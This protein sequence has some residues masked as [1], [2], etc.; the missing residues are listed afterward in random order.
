MMNRLG[1]HWGL[2]VPLC[3]SLS[4][5]R[6]WFFPGLI[7][8]DDFIPYSRDVLASYFPW[9]YFWDPGFHLGAATAQFSPGF[10]I[11][12]ASGA[13]A[14]L[15]F[16]WS[17]SE[18]LFWLFPY[19][20]G[21]PLTAYFLC[22]RLTRNTAAA[23]CGA[24]VFVLN[25]W[26][27]G[28]VQR[29][30]IPSLV[31]YTCMPLAVFGILKLN[32]SKTAKYAVALAIVLSV[33]VMYDLRYTYITCWLLIA[34]ALAYIIQGQSAHR[35]V[36]AVLF[37]AIAMAT[38]LAINLRWL[39]P[40][41]VAPTPFPPG[42]DTVDALM[43][44]SSQLTLGHALTLFY[45]FYH[46]VA[47]SAP[48]VRSQAEPL[49][50]IVPA[51]I[52]IG[53]AFL[54]PRPF[55]VGVALSALV[56]I[57]LVSGPASVV[58]LVSRWAF[59]HV[60]GMKLFRDITKWYS[61][62]AVCYAVLVSLTIARLGA[63]WQRVSTL[64]VLIPAALSVVFISIYVLA[65]HDAWN[66]QRL[67]NFA[68]SAERPEDSQL[69]QYINRLPGNS[70]VLVFP[71][72]TGQ[73]S[74]TNRHGIVDGGLLSTW[75]APDG[76]ASETT[77]VT[78][79][80]SFY[81]T[82]LAPI[83]MRDLNIAYFAVLDDPHGAMYRPWGFG[84]E[85]SDALRTFRGLHWLK[86]D[87]HFG[88]IVL[89]HIT[90]PGLAAYTASEPIFVDGNRSAQTAATTGLIR[91]FDAWMPA[92]NT[93]EENGHKYGNSGD[94]GGAFT[95]IRS[96]KSF[97]FGRLTGT[98]PFAERARPVFL[99]G[100][101]R[102]D[103][104]KAFRII[105]AFDQRDDAIVYEPEVFEKLGG[106]VYPLNSVAPVA[107]PPD[108]LNDGGALESAPAI[109]D[110]HQ[111]YKFG[112]HG[113]SISLINA[114]SS[115][116]TTRITFKGIYSAGNASCH[117]RIGN[118]APLPISNSVEAERQR[119]TV[120]YVA[121][122]VLRPGIN[123]MPVSLQGCDSR[124]ILF[125]DDVTLANSPGTTTS[126][127]ATSGALA[128]A[129]RPSR[130]VALSNRPVFSIYADRFPSDPPLLYTEFRLRDEANRARNFAFPLSFRYRGAYE[131]DIHDM[132]D[133]LVHD[134][135]RVPNVHWDEIGAWR[136]ESIR[137][138]IDGPK[139]AVR[140]AER[141]LISALWTRDGDSMHYSGSV[142]LN[143]A[144]ATSSTVLER[145]FKHE[146]IRIPAGTA[147]ADFTFEVPAPANAVQLDVEARND[148]AMSASVSGRGWKAGLAGR[149]SPG[150]GAKP[151]CENVK[152]VVPT[153]SLHQVS[154][155]FTIA[156]PPMAGSN[157][158]SVTLRLLQNQRDSRISRIAGIGNIVGLTA[159]PL[160]TRRSRPFANVLIDGVSAGRKIVTLRPGAHSIDGRI[161]DGQNVE[162]S[163]LDSGSEHPH[164]DGDRLQ[165]ITPT[166]Y[167]AAI[168]GRGIFVWPNGYA[169]GWKS[170]AISTETHLHGIAVLDYWAART[171]HAQ[172]L[173]H[174]VVDESINGWSV[175]SSKAGP[176]K[177]LL[178]LY[179][180][181]V[182]SELA[183]FAS[184]IIVAFWLLFLGIHK[185]RR[186]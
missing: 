96:E 6:A 20:I 97:L 173:H 40:Q 120:P 183:T 7:A 21:A 19:A 80:L 78:D 102:L 134:V 77:D 138:G 1:K 54:R 74:P 167:V 106:S 12:I 24:A 178:L 70:R 135:H 83:V 153:G 61:A 165:R 3:I 98:V 177:K 140:K 176:R 160:R 15:G 17:V 68:A 156:L 86:E 63:I 50:F 94:S 33:Q 2:L 172:E 22:F 107:T 4:V 10:P 27:I 55:V 47:G 14:K 11:W 13:L 25:P 75:S 174:Y 111:W 161:V 65:M 168:S 58:G 28:L 142:D 171:Q 169:V 129:L 87:R 170:Y 23:A 136:V 44:S 150:T 103:H 31:A 126:Q 186:R 45:P 112:I 119:S 84:I 147:N 179:V 9:R 117:I 164:S 145:N 66:R 116:R 92:L 91:P 8:G 34:I 158:V 159:K 62:I 132:I 71:Q 141:A 109:Q 29:G 81:R 53:L 73:P 182:A 130:T 144:Q 93:E 115:P 48:F 155:R 26:T 104:A 64:K 125:S 69:Q 162:A 41:F 108:L 36:R 166:E 42:Y 128:L 100:R 99:S 157:R 180:P 56:A 5:L 185:V 85:R 89:F 146:C 72:I 46:Y 38:F 123:I 184:L 76:Y 39:V 105:P 32:S 149:W 143:H 110:G 118:A 18:R 52:A 139:P 49:L 133:G 175:E 154:N 35:A 67:S 151:L 122:L 16:G 57:L 51:L 101:F 181:E 113:A 131:L 114:A 82:S 148:V 37:A 43:G 124:A 60:P 152:G 30:H 121:E 79:V 137:V 95:V 59:V 88:N 127:I 90:V 163:A